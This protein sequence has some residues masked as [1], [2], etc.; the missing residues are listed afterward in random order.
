MVFD[1]YYFG[2]VEYLSIVLACE[3]YSFIT[4][5]YAL[6]CIAIK[7]VRAYQLRVSRASTESYLH[8]SIIL[9]VCQNHA[10]HEYYSHL[11]T[12]FVSVEGMGCL[13]YYS[14][15]VLFIC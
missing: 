12:V 5:I 14:F 3:P 7:H 1:I 6:V 13:G 11:C 2:G 10:Y 15:T 9:S 8:R 4:D